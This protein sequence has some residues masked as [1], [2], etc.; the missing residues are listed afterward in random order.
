[1]GGV[2]ALCLTACSDDVYNDIETTED[3]SMY[4]TNSFNDGDPGFAFGDP[5]GS[6]PI[7]AGANYA[8]P[9]D[10]LFRNEDSK[11]PAY[12]MVNGDNENYSPYT[13]EIFAYVGLAYYDGVNNGSYDD[14]FTGNSFPI[15]NGNYPNLWDGTREVGNLVRIPVPFV[16]NPGDSSIRLEAEIDH[17]P[18]S[19]STTTGIPSPPNYVAYPDVFDFASSIT[20]DEEDILKQYGKVFFYE[21]NVWDAGT[22]VGN[23]LMH[24]NIETLQPGANLPSIHGGLWHEV[25]DVVGQP[26]SGVAPDGNNYPLYFYWNQSHNTGTEFQYNN[27]QNSTPLCDSREVVFQITSKNMHSHAMPNGRFLNMYILQ[28]SK[29]LWLNSMVVVGIQ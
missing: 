11:Q 21:V 20:A 1:M 28:N 8:S 29:Y 4:G 9:W 26:L 18:V 22:F 24:P 19:N 23:Y 5:G 2:I 15:N 12:I 10:F 14:P 3:E 7:W 17:L 27:L 16:L 25:T 13:I 6:G